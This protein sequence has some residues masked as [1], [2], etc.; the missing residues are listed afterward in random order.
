MYKYI[1]IISI[2]ICLYVIYIYYIYIYIHISVLF[3]MLFA[4][5]AINT[6][7]ERVLNLKETLY[8]KQCHF[9]HIISLK[10]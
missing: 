5:T 6:L 1:Y 4:L 10:S 2:Y 7:K 3:K 9:R 8:L